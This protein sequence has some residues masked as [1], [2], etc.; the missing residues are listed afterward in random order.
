VSPAASPL[1]LADLSALRERHDIF[2]VD[3]FGVLHD[4]QSAYA[5]AVDGLARLKASGATVVLLSN[6][7]KRSAP[8][9]ARLERLGFAKSGWDLFLSSGEVA[10]QAF[11]GGETMLPPA[12]RILLQAR[13]G[14]RSAIDGLDAS[15]AD[16][17]D[18]ADVV[19]LSGSEG[20]RV[21]IDFYKRVLEPAVRRDVPLYCTNPD[22]VMLTAVGPR[23]GAG[24]IADAYA[25]MGGRVSWIGKPHL[26]IYRAALA[27]LGEPDAGRVVGVGDSIE[28]DIA[29]ARGAGISAA[30]V[31]SGI[32]AELDAA[33]LAALCAEHGAVP[34]YLL[35]AFAWHV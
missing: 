9:E 14:D 12:A 20:D 21:D 31:R 25:A 8:N 4:G 33:G 7:G 30:L 35:P 28:H 34:D 1:A 6:S 27:A 22:K 26:Q 3:Q 16:N 19:L 29:G 32:L 24:A 23:F 18:D 15:L 2:F 17:G 5:G 13:D 10:W 11:S